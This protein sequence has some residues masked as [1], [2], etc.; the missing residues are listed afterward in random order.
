MKSI[1]GVNFTE[2]HFHC[3]SMF[4]WLKLSLFTYMGHMWRN[5]LL[6]SVNCMYLVILL[7]WETS[8]MVIW[9][10][11]QRVWMVQCS[12]QRHWNAH[13]KQCLMGK[14]GKVEWK[15]NGCEVDTVTGPPMEGVKGSKR[16]E[17][18]EWRWGGDRRRNSGRG[19][20]QR[21]VWGHDRFSKKYPQLFLK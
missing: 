3:K 17:K 15:L 14:G 5:F 7:N 13:R 1:C 10:G 18:S 20:R 8:S 11:R 21:G 16:V 2:Q 12:D 6:K 9:G 4:L 19:Q